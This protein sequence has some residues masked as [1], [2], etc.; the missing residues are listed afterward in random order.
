MKHMD[1]PEQLDQLKAGREDVFSS[2]FNAH[3]EGLFREAYYRLKNYNEAQDLV[4]DVFTDFWQ[5]RH[6]LEI[7][8]T[9]AA[10]LY[11]AMKYRVI[12]HITRARLHQDVIDHLVFQ[13]TVFEDSIVD[14]IAAGEV[15]KTLEDAVASFPE[16]MRNIFL[17]RN[18]DFT[19]A[20]IAEALD[21]SSQTVKNNTSEA[22]KRLKTV[23]AEKHP[24]IS[25]SLYIFLL[26]FIKS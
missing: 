1:V 24:D 26:L 2:I 21:L 11:S 5:R 9:L 13:M 18:Q 22:L 14:A 20:E 12:R 8:T 7:H 19:V 15:Q 25:S 23:L 4:Q 10:Y 16:N 17:L 3:W 6:S